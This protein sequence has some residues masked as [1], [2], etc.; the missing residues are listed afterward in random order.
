MSNRCLCKAGKQKKKAK[1]CVLP[2]GIVNFTQRRSEPHQA[3]TSTGLNHL[4]RRHNKLREG[5][6]ES[7]T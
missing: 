3:E 5:E 7:D 4:H 6:R 1:L 2:D